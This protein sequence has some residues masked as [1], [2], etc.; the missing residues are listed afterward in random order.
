MRPEAA[1]HGSKVVPWSALATGL[2]GEVWK[3]GGWLG[4]VWAGQPAESGLEGGRGS[5]SGSTHT[6]TGQAYL[7]KI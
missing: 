4:W 5:G 1:S 7:I 3:S 6:V 2:S